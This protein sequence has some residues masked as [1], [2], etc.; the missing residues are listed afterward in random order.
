MMDDE[1]GCAGGVSD[2]YQHLPLTCFLSADSRRAHR[3]IAIAISI[4]GI[5]TEHAKAIDKWLITEGCSFSRLDVAIAISAVSSSLP[6]ASTRF[7]LEEVSGKLLQYTVSES[8]LI[9]LQKA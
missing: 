7:E 6:F 3:V 8:S 9:P 4:L 2:V 5:S 1:G